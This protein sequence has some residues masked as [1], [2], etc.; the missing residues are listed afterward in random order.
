MLYTKLK[1]ANLLDYLELA[2]EIQSSFNYY[3]I[4]GFEDLIVDI[5][6]LIKKND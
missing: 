2:E 6:K 5:I 1:E 3:M 4:Y